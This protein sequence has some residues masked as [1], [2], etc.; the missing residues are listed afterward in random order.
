MKIV[1]AFW[2]ER[3]LGVTCYELELELSD[4]LESVEDTLSGLTQRQYMVAKIPSSR[5]DLVQLFQGKG[6]SFI[7]TAISLE[8]NFRKLNY[9]PPNIPQK[10]QKLCDRCS[11]KPM[12]NRDLA[13]LSE[14]IKKNMFTT[15]RVFVDPEFTKDQAAQRYDL[16]VKDLVKQGNIP[17]KVALDGETFGF[18]VDKEIAPAV[19]HAVLGG[20]YTEHKGPGLG[21]VL[22]Y[23]DF[24]S[25]VERRME[26]SFT[27]VSGSNPASLRLQ[28]GF[29]AEIKG[30]TYV[31]VKH[32]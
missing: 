26:R 31:L 22:Y 24:M 11:W 7:E 29:G 14:E 32:T 5:Y 9:T 23:A 21:Y 6:Y 8:F 27:S 16:W 2:E 15:D 17:Y 13:Q 28:V 30:L 3:N 20:V 12:D 10:L 25:R 4:C 1:D 19:Y 18:F